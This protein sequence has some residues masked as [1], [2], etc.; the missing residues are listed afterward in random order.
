VIEEFFVMFNRT[1]KG[2]SMVL[3]LALGGCQMGEGPALEAATDE[4]QIARTVWVSPTGDDA[5]D[6]RTTARPKRT[7]QAAVDLLGAGGTRTG[8]V[9]LMPG[10]Y[11]DT[12]NVDGYTN[13]RIIGD[14][15]DTVTWRPGNTLGW[16]V[17]TFGT[18]RRT[19]VRIVGSLNVTLRSVTLDFTTVRGDFVAGVLM[20]NST[21][22]FQDNVF[23]NM[24]TAGY[25]EFTTYV[26]APASTAAQRAKVRFLDNEFLNTGRLGVVLHGYSHG[27]LLRNTFRADADFGY[28]IEVASTATANIREN[29]IGGYRTSAATDGSASAGIYIENAFTAGVTGV[30]KSVTVRANNL[31]DNGYGVTIGNAFAGLAGDVDVAVALDSNLIVNNTLAGVAIT[32]EGRSAGSSVTVTA[33]NNLLANNGLRG[34]HIYTAGN[35]EVH[36]TLTREVI[37]GHNTAVEVG[38]DS[39]ASLHDITVTA[40][41]LGDNTAWGLRNLGPSVVSARN[42]WWG[43]PDG[44]TDLF[45]TTE[46]TYRSCADTDVAARLNVA[47]DTFGLPGIAVSERV[48]YCNWSRVG[49]P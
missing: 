10:T 9:R 11:T 40:S 46:V 8:T 25:Y 20:W 16:N 14:G 17:S 37:S 45:G 30:A 18:T 33:R 6:G 43:A 12:L 44:P 31:H 34:Y 42:N 15:R 13:L 1:F 29:D 48:D 4:V 23:E 27:E 28:A 5:N 2:C 32:D 3:A 24:G 39:G 19:P 7:I 38:A 47:G 22:L 49:R 21:G 36:S 26:S 41:N 35:G